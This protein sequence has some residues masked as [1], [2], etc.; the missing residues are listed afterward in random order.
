P[1]LEVGGI[2]A[3]ARRVEGRGPQLARRGPAD[4]GVT[5]REIAG[6][7]GGGDRSGL[8]WAVEDEWRARND[9]ELAERPAEDLDQ[10][11]G[12]HQREPVPGDATA[13]SAGLTRPGTPT[14]FT[15]PSERCS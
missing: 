7:V 12:E 9:D 1:G 8:W 10:C 15:V 11:E 3:S 6:E 4:I 2:R 14:H 13:A 5:G